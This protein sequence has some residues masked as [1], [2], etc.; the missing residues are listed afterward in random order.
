MYFVSLASSPLHMKIFTVNTIRENTILR[1]SLRPEIAER[2]PKR[3]Y[4]RI[5]DD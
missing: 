1:S 5:K 2:T 3:I 4:E